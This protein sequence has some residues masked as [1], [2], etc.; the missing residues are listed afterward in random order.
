[1]GEEFRFLM[2]DE[3]FRFLT[4]GGECSASSV[5]SSTEKSGTTD[6]RYIPIFNVVVSIST[7]TLL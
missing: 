6:R 4:G 3:E 1:M 7:P 5:P 2:G